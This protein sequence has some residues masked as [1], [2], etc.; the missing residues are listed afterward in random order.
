VENQSFAGDDMKEGSFGMISYVNRL[1]TL[2]LIGAVT[3]SVAFA[4]TVKKKI[5]FEHPVVVNGTVVKKGTYVAVF[6][7]QTNELTIVKDKEVIAK[8]PARLEKRDLPKNA[9]L[10]SSDDGAGKVLATIVLN[11]NNQ[12]TIVNG[13]SKSSSAQ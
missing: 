6:D 2:L 13:E 9:L 3:S 8:A 4:E 10:F 11:G 1:A 12:A 5:T 7:D